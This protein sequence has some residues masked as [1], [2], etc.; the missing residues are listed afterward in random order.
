MLPKTGYNLIEPQYFASCY[1]YANLIH[2]LSMLLS[3]KNGC[4][5]DYFQHK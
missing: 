2:L 3:F 1:N 5:L 4:N